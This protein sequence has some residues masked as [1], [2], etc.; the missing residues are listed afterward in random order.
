ME[1]SKDRHSGVD[2]IFAFSVRRRSLFLVNSPL[3]VTREACKS[4][5][6]VNV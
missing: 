6:R 2:D 1:T 3:D 4:A 5:S